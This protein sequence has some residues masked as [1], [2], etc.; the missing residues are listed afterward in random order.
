VITQLNNTFKELIH[1]KGMAVIETNYEKKL[2][3]KEF[4][5]KPGLRKGSYDFEMC[6]EDLEFRNLVHAKFNSKQDSRYDSTGEGFDGKIWYFF[7]FKGQPEGKVKEYTVVAI[8]KK[9]GDE[10][11]INIENSDLE[12]LL[13]KNGFEKKRLK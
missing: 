13:I 10:S 9:V 6:D 4:V 5:E 12:K 8:V 1:K 2:N 7:S 11:V 3:G